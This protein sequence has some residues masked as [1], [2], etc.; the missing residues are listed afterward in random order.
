M[1]FNRK[2][3]KSVGVFAIL[4]GPALHGSAHSRAAGDFRSRQR[5][6]LVQ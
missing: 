2:G 6:G 3:G 1:V 4:I 5:A